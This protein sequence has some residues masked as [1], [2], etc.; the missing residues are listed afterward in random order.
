MKKQRRFETVLEALDSEVSVEDFTRE[1][2][3][4]LAFGIKFF[5][6]DK[7]EEATERR[8]ARQKEMQKRL[9][10]IERAEAKARREAREAKVKE[11]REEKIQEAIETGKKVVI[12]R[13]GT[14]GGNPYADEI[15]EYA[16][17]DGT[18]KTV[19]EK[20]NQY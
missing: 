11:H 18:T 19:R 6:F 17:P 16:M 5:T 8:I 14:D 7:K 10:E 2:L 1:E 12:S 3:K 9:K 20:R 15:V 13:E 4:S